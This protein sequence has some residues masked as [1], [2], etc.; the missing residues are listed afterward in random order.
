[1]KKLKFGSAPSAA[2]SAHSVSEPLITAE[3]SAVGSAG[4]PEP[5]GAGVVEGCVDGLPTGSLLELAA[6]GTVTVLLTEGTTVL[7]TPGVVV[8]VPG[9]AETLGFVLGAAP[10][11]APGVGVEAPVLGLADAVAVAVTVGTEVELAGR[12]ARN[13]KRRTPRCRR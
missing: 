8:A 3:H 10:V 4:E 12:I 1:M 9:D 2:V 5:P 6:G 7:G 11:E 13:P